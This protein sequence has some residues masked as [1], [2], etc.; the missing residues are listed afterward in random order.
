MRTMWDTNSTVAEG[1]KVGDTLILLLLKVFFVIARNSRK[2]SAEGASVILAIMP[3]KR[4]GSVARFSENRGFSYQRSSSDEVAPS[5]CC[6]RRVQHHDLHWNFRIK[7]GR[8]FPDAMKKENNQYNAYVFE[9]KNKVYGVLLWSRF[10]HHR[11]DRYYGGLLMAVFRIEKMRSP[12]IRSGP[13][14]K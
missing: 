1:W 3:A 12:P 9:E 8:I 6:T 5:W 14:S 7:L 2:V 10:T 11:I 4:G 13:Y